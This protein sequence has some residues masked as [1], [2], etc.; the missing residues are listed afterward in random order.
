MTR[1]EIINSICCSKEWPGICR[2]IANGNDIHQDLFQEFVLVLYQIPEDKLTELNSTGELQWYCV[3]IIMNMFHGENSPF[4][5]SYRQR[6]MQL[7]P[8]VEDVS[9]EYNP[10]MDKELERVE[11]FLTGLPW[12][13]R[14]IFQGYVKI[15]SYRKFSAEVG[16]VA[17]SIAATVQKVRKKYKKL[18]A[19]T[20]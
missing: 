19:A 18:R 6:G 8:A 4:F 2:K 17:C 20:V 16:I 10:E 11:K 13:E 3:K 5:R 15:G 14:E 9:E 12:Y 1:L 7:S